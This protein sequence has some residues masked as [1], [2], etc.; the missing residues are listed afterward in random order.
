LCLVR[1]QARHCNCAP[2]SSGCLSITRKN[3]SKGLTLV[4]IAFLSLQ[5]LKE[6][7]F[8]PNQN[9]EGEVTL[10]DNNE[11]YNVNSRSAVRHEA[12]SA[13]AFGPRLR[14]PMLNCLITRRITFLQ[15]PNLLE[16]DVKQG[17]AQYEGQRF[18]VTSDSGQDLEHHADTGFH[19]LQFPTLSGTILG[20]WNPRTAQ[21]QLRRTLSITL[22]SLVET[23]RRGFKQALH[24]REL[25]LRA[26]GR[27]QPSFSDYQY[28]M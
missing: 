6:P 15:I 11:P 19:D 28:Q 9:P 20:R 8:P 17:S 13:L 1:L 23:V 5:D 16:G 4:E 2:S 27:W 24:D 26:L 21:R 22:I 18:L 10:R 12:G 25:A 3:T 14:L 7:V